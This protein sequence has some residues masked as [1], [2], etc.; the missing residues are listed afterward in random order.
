MPDTSATRFLQQENLRLQKENETLQRKNQSL[1]RRLERIKELYWASQNITAEENMLE[2]LNELLH[3][4]MQVIDAEDGSLS[5]L[6][7]STGEL[8]FAL[9]QGH[10]GQ[11]LQGFKIKSDVGI[12]GWVVANYEPVIVNN[13]RQDW[14]FSIMIDERF[15]FFTRSIVSV[16]VIDQQKLVGVIQLLNKRHGEFDEADVAVLLILGQVAAIALRELT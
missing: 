13:P 5:Y 8:V 16:P 9:A 12:V 6:D 7:E 4:T 3:D 1:G 10:I 15:G 2:A 14:R 11:Q